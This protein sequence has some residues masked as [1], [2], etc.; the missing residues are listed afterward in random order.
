MR[1]TKEKPKVIEVAARGIR[2]MSDVSAALSA[3][4]ADVA[5]GR[6]TT[7]QANKVSKAAGK[8]IKKAYG[9]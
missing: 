5:A 4:M 9:K 8:L 2:S 1:A 7:A 3:T 6:I